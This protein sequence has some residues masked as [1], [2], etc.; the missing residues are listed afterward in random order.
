MARP[1]TLFTGQWGLSKGKMS[2][3]EYERFLDEKARPVFAALPAAKQE[4]CLTL[5]PPLEAVLS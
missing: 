2:A 3:D 4:R 1:V 5:E